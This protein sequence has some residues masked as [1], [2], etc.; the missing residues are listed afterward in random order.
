MG[1]L[2]PVLLEDRVQVVDDGL[3]SVRFLL[4][5]CVV[6]IHQASGL[7]SEVGCRCLVLAVGVLG[8]QAFQ[9]VQGA[10]EGR[11]IGGLTELAGRGQLRGSLLL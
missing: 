3:E 4:S 9:F 5:I 11:G 7:V 1:I 10:V 2:Q 6:L 8:D